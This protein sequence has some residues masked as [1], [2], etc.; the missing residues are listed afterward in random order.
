MHALEEGQFEMFGIL[1]AIA[2]L[3][4]C[5]GPHFLC[6]SLA[7]F[8]LD[9]PVEVVL[10]QSL[11]QNLFRFKAVIM[12]LSF[13]IYVSSFL[14]RFDMWYTKPVITLDDKDDL[15]RFCSKQIV[16]SSVAEEIFSFC[17]GL[18]TFGVLHELCKFSEARMAELVYQDVNTDHVKACFKYYLKHE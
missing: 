11:K 9:N 4:G 7:S 3:N 5:P 1:T 12:N 8:I 14:E 18:S 15:I 17:K 10:N 2:L 16:I 13:Q 6:R